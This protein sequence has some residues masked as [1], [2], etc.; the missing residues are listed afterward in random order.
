MESTTVEQVD[1][2]MG[3][4]VR[5]LVV[6]RQQ[7]AQVELQAYMKKALE[8]STMVPAKVF[9]KINIIKNFSAAPLMYAKYPPSRGKLSRSLNMETLNAV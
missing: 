4:L 6:Q 3:S 7:L 1:T 5:P 8:Q 9:E 2:M